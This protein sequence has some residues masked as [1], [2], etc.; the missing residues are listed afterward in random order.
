[1]NYRLLPPH[2][3]PHLSPDPADTRISSSHLLSR[4]YQPCTQE[5]KSTSGEVC[6][7]A[8]ALCPTGCW[9]PFLLASPCSNS[10]IN[11]CLK[12]WQKAFGTLLRLLEWDQLTPK[13][14]LVSR[15]KGCTD[16]SWVTRTLLAKPSTLLCSSLFQCCQALFRQL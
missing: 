8:P 15:G 4:T 11:Y 1:M 16:L 13:L 14:G 7:K 10:K 5:A 3:A 9:Q 12:S 2:L 6:S